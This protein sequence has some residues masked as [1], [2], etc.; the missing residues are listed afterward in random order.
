MLVLLLTASV[1]CAAELSNQEVL[2]DTI[3]EMWQGE[4]RG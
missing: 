2:T 3:W 1:F 4:V